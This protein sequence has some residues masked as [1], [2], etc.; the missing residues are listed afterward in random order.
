MGA[1]QDLN[2]SSGPLS[3]DHMT[4]SK[5]RSIEGAG[6][7]ELNNNL[8]IKVNKQDIDDIVNIED[9]EDADSIEEF[10]DG[11]NIEDIEDGDSIE[12]LD[13]G[14]TIEDLDGGENIEELVDIEN[15]EE[16]DD[17]EK[18]VD[19]DDIKDP[20]GIEDQA[21][22]PV[23]S[24]SYHPYQNPKTR[25]EKLKEREDVDFKNIISYTIVLTVLWPLS[26]FAIFGIVIL[27]KQI[28]LSKLG[29]NRGYSPA[30]REV[31]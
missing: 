22:K 10:D 25:R 1:S 19:L 12:E 29:P 7:L 26:V 28:I 2:E 23:T 9:V 31:V 27:V 15:V 14:E 6:C 21:E 17:I 30:Q 8:N 4:F 13:D 20:D 18:I 24:K 5:V 16:L 3:A 11:E